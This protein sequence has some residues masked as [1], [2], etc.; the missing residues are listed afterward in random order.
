MR[1]L[2]SPDSD[3]DYRYNKTGISIKEY[4]ER[5]RYGEYARRYGEYAR[6]YGEYARNSIVSG[7]PC[8]SNVKEFAVLTQWFFGKPLKLSGLDVY[9]SPIECSVRWEVKGSD[10]SFYDGKFEDYKIW[11]S[12]YT[13]GERFF[14]TLFGGMTCGAPSSG[15]SSKFINTKKYRHQKHL[16]SLAKDLVSSQCGKGSSSIGPAFVRLAAQSRERREHLNP[17]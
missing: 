13:V 14:A 17:E 5:L 6:R 11:G 12:S 4:R 8:P 1:I 2:Q 3:S 9:S 7:I 16:E 15:G 10:V